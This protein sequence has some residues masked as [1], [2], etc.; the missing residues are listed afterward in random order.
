MNM[1]RI[2]S[3]YEKIFIRSAWKRAAFYKKHNFFQKIGGC[4]IAPHIWPNETYLISMG[5]D[6]WLTGGVQLINHDAS[7]QVIKE[8]KN[9]DWIDKIGRISFGNHVFVGNHSIIMPGVNIGNNVVIGA[10]SVVTKDI[11]SNSVAVGNP[12][13]VVMSFDE[14]VEKCIDHTKEY[15]WSASDIGDALIQKRIKYFWEDGHSK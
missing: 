6:V 10:G 8:A 11:P 7:V 3:F 1:K 2:L 4:Y 13:H 14:Y 5:D 9:L 15:P 12:A